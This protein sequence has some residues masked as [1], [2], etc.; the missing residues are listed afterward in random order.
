MTLS[1]PKIPQTA[2]W[3]LFRVKFIGGTS[4]TGKAPNSIKAEQMARRQHAGIVS[5]VR[6]VKGKS[7]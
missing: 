2:N 3:P 1:T 7:R 5:K 6:I 4:F